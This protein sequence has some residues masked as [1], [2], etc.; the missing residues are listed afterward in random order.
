MSLRLFAFGAPR[1]ERQ[2]RA[3]KVDTRKALALLVYLLRTGPQRRDALAGLLWTGELRKKRASLRR[4]L[5]ALG[6]ALGDGLGRDR[7]QAW[8]EPGAV[9]CDVEAFLAGLG[10]PD[11]RARQQ[12]LA[13]HARPFLEG[14]VLRGAAAFDDWRSRE[15]EH[16]RARLRQGWEGWLEEAAP[17]ARLEPARRWRFLDPLHEPAHRALIRAYREAGQIEAAREAW[18][19][20]EAMLEEQGLRP[21]PESLALTATLR[22][23]ASA[24]RRE[25]NRLYGRE[26]ERAAL[27]RLWAAPDCRL[28]TLLGPAGCGKTALARDFAASRGGFVELAADSDVLP[29]LRAVSGPLLL[30]GCECG[31][32]A[33]RA[34]AAALAGLPGLRVLATSRR[35]LGVRGEHVFPLAGLEEA[36]ARALFLA[37]AEQLRG[38]WN[39]AELEDFPALWRELG[40]HP[41]ALELAAAWFRVLDCGELLAEWRADPG[42]LRSPLRD[43]P[44]AHRDLRALFEAA[45]AELSPTRQELVER[46]V[47]TGSGGEELAEL[48]ALADRAWLEPGAA[49][50]R[51]VPVWAAFVRALSR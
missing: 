25:P 49:G 1:L 29:R 8:I 4:T 22:A 28:V 44:A 18:G 11:P 12:A 16:L 41:L 19:A 32:E 36:P 50:P 35:R 2:G 48:A 17:E 7:H 45:W 33:C 5:S 31:L 26:R 37:R 42:F 13:L 23:V 14:F 51:V 39:D 24:A 34:G 46:L 20:L 43:A 3:V 30:D 38:T 21:G 9:W 40:G 47:A 6:K 27:E 10:D 15:A